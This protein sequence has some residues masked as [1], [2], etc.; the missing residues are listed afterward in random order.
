MVSFEE[1]PE[2]YCGWAKSHTSRSDALALFGKPV[3]DGTWVKA[4]A[5]YVQHLAWSQF[6][7]P[8]TRAAASELRGRLIDK[9]VS[10]PL[11]DAAHA[12]LPSVFNTADEARLA[13]A[14]KIVMWLITEAGPNDATMIADLLQTVVW[15]KDDGFVRDCFPLVR[16]LISKGSSEL[17]SGRRSLM[18]SNLVPIVVRLEADDLLAPAIRYVLYNEH[19]VGADGWGQQTLERLLPAIERLLEQSQSSEIVGDLIEACDPSALRSCID[20]A[21]RGW[22][23]FRRSRSELLKRLARGQLKAEGPM[24]WALAL[25]GPALDVEML[26][27]TTAREA[28]QGL[29]GYGREHL[30]FLIGDATQGPSRAAW[31]H[32]IAREFLRT[33]DLLATRTPSDLRQLQEC[34]GH[35][36]MIADGVH[37]ALREA[38]ERSDDP[39]L[40]GVREML[41]GSGTETTVVIPAL[42]LLISAPAAAPRARKP[43]GLGHV[44]EA[45]EHALLD[46]GPTVSGF[47]LKKAVWGADR[48]K[49]VDLRD[50]L[51]FVVDGDTLAISK[52]AIEELCGVSEDPEVQR[53]L[54]V[55]YAVHEVVHD[56]QGIAAKNRVSE[57][58]FAGAESALMHIDLGAD[59]VAAVV[60]ASIFPEWDLLWLKD[61]QGKSIRSFPATPRNPPCSRIRKTLRLVGLRM[62]LALRK[63]NIGGENLTA[64]SYGFA[65]FAPSG[66][67]FIA[68]LNRPPFVVVKTSTIAASDAGILF[69]GIGGHEGAIERVDEVV[70]RVLIL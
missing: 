61:W 34:A 36:G 40:Q 32:I 1:N 22:A 45:V 5:L 50:E 55:L 24:T 67:A 8:A 59:H 17:R 18:V 27:V 47:S 63:L 12:A 4:P 7:E 51:A 56:F 11:T 60:T 48:V 53:A 20:L 43:W 64:E 68:M 9:I 49:V 57:V 46:D 65:D 31:G 30:A 58:R 29:L 16:W 66:G 35:D 19:R 2:A 33:T 14:P 3:D 52:A 13:E 62:D 44:V 25:V 41:V 21:L 6:W 70:E 28:T 54:G 42:E 23:Q 26:D 15:S 38:V 69:E 37:A 39:T 10:G